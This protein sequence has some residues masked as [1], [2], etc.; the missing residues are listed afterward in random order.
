VTL[1]IWRKDRKRGKR[2]AAWALRHTLTSPPQPEEQPLL[3]RRRRAPPVLKV[4]QIAWTCDSSQV[5][6]SASPICVLPLY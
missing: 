3:G 2:P 5:R 1:Q 4:N 6:L